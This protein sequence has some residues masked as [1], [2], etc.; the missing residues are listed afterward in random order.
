MALTGSA[1]GA[2]CPLNWAG[3]RVGETRAGWL[4]WVVAAGPSS[5]WRS[6][7]SWSKPGETLLEVGGWAGGVGGGG[8]GGGSEASGWVR[9]WG[10]LEGV[11]R[12]GLGM[13]VGSGGGRV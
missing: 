4:N 13:K 10:G 11:G 2:I 8:G 1:P 6:C 9:D 3:G 12:G 7:A 5:G